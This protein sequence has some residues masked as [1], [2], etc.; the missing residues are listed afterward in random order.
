MK[1]LEI[2]KT[3]PTSI[4]S[5]FKTDMVKVGLVFLISNFFVN[6]IHQANNWSTKKIPSCTNLALGQASKPFSSFLTT[7]QNGYF[8]IIMIQ[9]CC[10]YSR[11]AF[12]PPFDSFLVVLFEQKSV[13]FHNGSKLV[14]LSY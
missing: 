2:E 9:I 8:L 10:A 14:S 5:T 11:A 7:V 13:F 4:I 12:V 6:K 1:K 3:K